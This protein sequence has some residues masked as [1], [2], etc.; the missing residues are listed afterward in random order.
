MVV[1]GPRRRPSL[2]ER[3]EQ[4]G[5][6]D[7]PELVLAAAARFLEA[8]PRAV[9]EVRRRLRQAGYR[10]DLVEGAIGR[11]VELGMLDD[12]A[13][14][15][16]WTESRD[17]SRPRGESV[18]RRELQ[19]RGVGRDTIDAALEARRRGERTERLGE[20]ID[21]GLDRDAGSPDEAA[22]FRLLDRRAA[23]LARVPDPRVRRQKAYALL[24]RNGFDP[25]VCSSVSAAWLRR[26]DNTDGARD[27]DD[28]TEPDED[29]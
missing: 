11:L 13:F 23:A 17:R 10:P 12:D 6:V 21:D 3:R 15:R 9:G 22:A 18:L 16:A 1:R 8:R 5:A 7:D 27:E 2:A 29:E 14:A 20:A 25:G 19:L 4:R 26:G 24:A 28:A